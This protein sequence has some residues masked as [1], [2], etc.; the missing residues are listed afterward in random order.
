MVL[1]EVRVQQ[2]E[3]LTGQEIDIAMDINLDLT[4][5][6]EADVVE[7]A[8]DSGRKVQGRCKVGDSEGSNGGCI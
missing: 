1:T 7:R 8:W 3:N 2:P 6:R 5:L 4:E